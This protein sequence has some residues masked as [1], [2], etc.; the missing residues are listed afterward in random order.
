[1]W[2]FFHLPLFEGD[3]QRA[4]SYLAPKWSEFSLR[5]PIGL[6]SGLVVMGEREPGRG[7]KAEEA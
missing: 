2:S 6:M 1:M 7:T 4:E 5:E 3:W